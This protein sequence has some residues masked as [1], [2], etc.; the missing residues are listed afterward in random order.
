[1]KLLPA[2]LMPPTSDI[3]YQE[4]VEAL[5]ADDEVEFA[6][7][8]STLAATGRDAHELACDVAEEKRGQQFEDE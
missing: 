1:M 7:V 3:R 8:A 4:L 5:A 2:P 6:E